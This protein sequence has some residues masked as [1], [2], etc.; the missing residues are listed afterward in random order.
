LP[1]WSL[2]QAQGLGLIIHQQINPK[3]TN[4]GSSGV[5]DQGAESPYYGNMSVALFS[6]I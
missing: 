3:K 6:L 4:E 1:N 5:K 2:N